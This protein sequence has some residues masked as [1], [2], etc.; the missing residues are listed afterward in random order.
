MAPSVRTYRSNPGY[1]LVP[2]AD[3][4]EAERSS[5]GSVS[6][7][8]A[9]YGVLVP[10][11][12]QSLTVKVVSHDTADLFL[13]LW[14]GMPLPDDRCAVTTTDLDD[15]VAAEILGI[16]QDGQFLTG[17]AALAMLD[18]PAGRWPAG[19]LPD[20]VLARL[21]L[22]AVEYVQRLDLSN[23]AAMSG[24]LYAYNR[25]PVGPTFQRWW[26]NGVVRSR[27]DD[28]VS[29][30]S[31]PSDDWQASTSDPTWSTYARNDRSSQL[32]SDSSIYK[33][34]VSPLP[35]HYFA[36]LER[37][38]A[39]VPLQ[40]EVIGWKAGN[41]LRALLRPDKLVVYFLSADAV[42]SFASDL[43]AVLD[44]VPAQGVPFTAELGSDGLLSWGVD[45]P[46]LSTGP[47]SVLSDSWRTWL[48]DRLAG[49]L[50][51]ATRDGLDGP[52]AC[53]AALHRL[54]VAGVDTQRWMPT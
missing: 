32:G 31:H 35:D 12:Q 45:P 50:W 23:P 30:A 11:K 26:P 33:L 54:R 47:A 9:L 19:A 52:S 6:D 42:R 24:R 17:L 5:L 7:D 14:S 22:A 28:V 38:V 43:L 4:G 1:R 49:A 37:V 15:L 40:P 20:G 27:L 46:R 39:M 18:A 44:G 21:S 51:Q 13:D 29:S 8:P 2:F 36:T 10:H 53:D 25:I 41:D 3:L 34:Y 16:E 48:T